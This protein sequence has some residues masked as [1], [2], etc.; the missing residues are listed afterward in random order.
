MV[1]VQVNPCQHNLRALNEQ[2]GSSRM[3]RSANVLDRFPEDFMSQ[4]TTEETKNLR[5]QIGTSR[6]GRGGRRQ[7]SL[8]LSAWVRGKKTRSVLISE[9]TVRPMA[10]EPKRIGVDREQVQ[11]NFCA[12]IPVDRLVGRY[13]SKGCGLRL[14]EPT[15]RRV[16]QLVSMPGLRQTARTLR[17]NT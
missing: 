12:D 7:N 3:F 6:A 2:P 15:P 17:P 14:V 10:N 9:N 11:D 4:L 8:C 16:A 1:N 13:S 5:F